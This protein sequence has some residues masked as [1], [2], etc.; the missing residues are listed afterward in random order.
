VVIFGGGGPAVFTVLTETDP[1]RYWLVCGACGQ[2]WPL[3]PDCKLLPQTRA[4][5]DM[6]TDCQ[7]RVTVDQ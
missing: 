7:E 4:V 2:R 6:H 3:E 5:F 1:T